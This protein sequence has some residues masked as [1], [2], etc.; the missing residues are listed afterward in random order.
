[1][2]R[3]DQSG[4]PEGFP[5]PPGTTPLGKAQLRQRSRELLTTI[6]KDATP[7]ELRVVG[8][9][10]YHAAMVGLAAGL[11]GAGFFATLEFVQRLLLENLGGYRPLRASGETFMG[12]LGSAPHFRPWLVALLPAVGA[13]IGGIC[14]QLAPETYGGGGDATINAFHH[15]DGQ[16]RKRV[17]WVK[18]LSSIFTLGTGGSGGREGPTMQIG[19][20]LGSLCGRLLR[21]GV[22]ERRILMV[23]GVAAGIAAVF[24][25]PLGAALLAVEVLYRDDFE[26]DA[27]I[28]AVL[29]SVT[30]Y[31]VVISIFGESTLFAHPGRFPFVITHLWLYGL[32]ALMVSALAVMFLAAL[33]GVQRITAGLTIPM[34]ARPGLGGLAM[35]VF[36][37]P[38]VVFIGWRLAQPG[39][40]LGLFGG[41]YGAVQ[42]AITGASWLP[43]GWAGAGLLLFLCLAK[44]VASSLTIGSGGSA[45]DFA[46]A[47]VIGGLFG[48]A[49]GRV[50]QM[51][52]HD[53]RIDPG[54]FALVAMGTFYGG[55]AHTPLSSLVLVCELA[56]SY[57][58]LVPL[59]L[60]EGIAFVALRR[61]S[62]YHAQVKSRRESP[63]H[64]SEDILRTTRVGA[65]MRMISVNGVP[66]ASRD[67]S[68]PAD[69]DLRT[70]AETMLANKLREIQVTDAQGQVVGLLD[71]ADISRCYL[72][73]ADRTNTSA[74]IPIK[75]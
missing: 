54:A 33:R 13:L 28:P 39:Q 41:G 10:L 40:G 73:A 36:C 22:Q 44:I 74:S 64:R 51:L 56:G 25:T 11:M 65:V 30:A 5:D 29:A 26:S 63:V 12:E 70:A 45:G 53:P 35:G 55:I 47:L 57:D 66:V 21:V 19:G 1:M 15:G 8:R 42:V 32:L 59:M 9:T 6:L 48:G 52:I 14:S 2:K 62:L 23:S 24:R 61:R 4:P 20:A 71:E 50:A 31:S 16:I 3:D 69:A 58:L 34:W 49:F 68:V 43:G 75:P 27:L 72:D 18:A 67:F 7:R 46:P 60:A 17:S 37:V 38:I